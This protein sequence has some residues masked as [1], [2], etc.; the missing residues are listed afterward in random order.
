MKHKRDFWI[1]HL[2]RSGA[3]PQNHN[4]VPGRRFGSVSIVNINNTSRD[5]LN[6]VP[7]KRLHLLLHWWNYSA[8][9]DPWV[10]EQCKLLLL[11]GHKQANFSSSRITQARSNK[12]RAV[13]EWVTKAPIQMFSPLHHFLDMDTSARRVVNRREE[14]ILYKRDGTIITYM[15]SGTV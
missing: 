10:E 4:W 3:I 14:L 5:Y 13:W 15:H 2:V 11:E 9:L 8:K 6:L 12:E 7:P 1:Y